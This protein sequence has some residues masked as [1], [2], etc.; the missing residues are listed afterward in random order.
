MPSMT[1]NRSRLI[2]AMSLCCLLVFAFLLY[3]MIFGWGPTPAQI[4]FG[5]IR[6]GM[7]RNEVIEILGIPNGRLSDPNVLSWGRKTDQIVV[8]LDSDGN[9]KNKEYWD[10]SMDSWWKQI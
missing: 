1:R 7:S 5:Q 4:Q 10:A 8:Y 2:R 6:V 9:V 3:S